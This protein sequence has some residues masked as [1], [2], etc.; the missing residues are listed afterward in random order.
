[1]PR[2]KRN[3]HDAIR[4]LLR[5][6]E[7]EG[8]DTKEINMTLLTLAIDYYTRLEGRENMIHCLD[9]FAAEMRVGETFLGSLPQPGS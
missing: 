3:P 8:N 2:R 4:K 5:E 1:M 9:G 7:K 6:L